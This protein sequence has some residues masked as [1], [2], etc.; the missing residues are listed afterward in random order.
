MKATNQTIE[1]RREVAKINMKR[2]RKD[3]KALGL[4][5][6]CGSNLREAEMARLRRRLAE[7]EKARE[8]DGGS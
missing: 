1:E 8:Q 4:C 3:R 6:T 5:V 2:I 7:L